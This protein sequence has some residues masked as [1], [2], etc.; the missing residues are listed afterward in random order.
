M[1]RRSTRNG[2][3]RGLRPCQPGCLCLSPGIAQ[4]VPNSLQGFGGEGR[5]LRLGPLS[6]GHDTFLFASLRDLSPLA[7]EA[8]CKLGPPL[9]CYNVS[10]MSVPRAITAKGPRYSS[11]R[12][13]GILPRERT[14]TVGWDHWYGTYDMR[15]VT[16]DTWN[17]ELG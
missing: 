3:L 7:P 8:E 16:V 17:H 15:V 5:S 13:P 1:R 10:G 11:R 14:R 9:L 4:R 2:F 12:C 6:S